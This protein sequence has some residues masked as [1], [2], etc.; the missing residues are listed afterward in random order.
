MARQKPYG[1]ARKIRHYPEHIIVEVETGADNAYFLYH[2]SP[3]LQPKYVFPS[4]SHEFSHRDLELAGH[5]T[6]SW[7]SCPELDKP[8]VLNVWEPGTGWHEETIRWR[9][10]PWRD[11]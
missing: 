11:Q 5:I 6:H 3:E 7:D 10:N 1:H 2:F 4:G 9:D 8:L